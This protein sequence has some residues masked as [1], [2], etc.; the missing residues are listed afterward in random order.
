MF[1]DHLDELPVY[2]M[3]PALVIQDKS[4]EGSARRGLPSTNVSDGNRRPRARGLRKLKRELARPFKPYWPP[5]P[6]SRKWRLVRTKV[7]FE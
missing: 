4:V 2:Q 7:P 1:A 3:T 5:G 6:F